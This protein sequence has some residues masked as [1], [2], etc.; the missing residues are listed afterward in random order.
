MR[1]L[2]KKKDEELQWGV[3]Q[4]INNHDSLDKWLAVLIIGAVLNA[5]LGI[6]ALILKCMGY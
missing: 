3:P 4:P 2:K 1:K 6:L 5:M